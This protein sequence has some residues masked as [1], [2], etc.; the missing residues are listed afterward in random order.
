M[1]DVTAQGIRPA[2]AWAG[3]AEAS[4]RWD[5]RCVWPLGRQKRRPLG[6]QTRSSFPRKES[7]GIRWTAPK[8]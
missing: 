4:G 2:E 3:T 1:T 6:R 5:D 7:Y 8:C